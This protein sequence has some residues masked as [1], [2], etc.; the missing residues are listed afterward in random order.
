[1]KQAIYKILMTERYDWAIYSWNYGVELRDLFGKPVSY[2]VPEIERRVTEALTQDGRVLSVGGWAFEYPARGTVKA[3]FTA[4]TVFGDV[5][6][7]TEV[8][9]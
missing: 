1:M 7:E 5:E 8:N 3:R 9:V 2:C 6:A 4:R